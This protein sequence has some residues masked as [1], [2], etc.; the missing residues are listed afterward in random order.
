MNAQLPTL[1]PASKVMPSANLPSPQPL[2][3]DFTHPNP[4]VISAYNLC[5]EAE[6]VVDPVQDHWPPDD[7]TVKAKVINIRILGHLLCQRHLLSDTAIA[8]VAI[9]IVSCRRVTTGMASEQA[10]I[11]GLN[12]LGEFYRNYLLRPCKCRALGVGTDLSDTTAVEFA[13]TRAAPRTLRRTLL[14][15]HSSSQKR[16]STKCSPRLPRVT[17]TRE[18]WCVISNVFRP[19]LAVLIP[20]V[21]NATRGL[22]LHSDAYTRQI[23]RPRIPPSPRGPDP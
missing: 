15:P 10:D 11:E 4:T 12:E 20:P 5:R 21:G 8:R 1:D 2:W 9:G 17:P 6:N 16:R 18:I 13:S 19:A 7:P 14:V 22:P 23:L 3:A